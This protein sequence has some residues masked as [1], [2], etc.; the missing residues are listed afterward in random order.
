MPH[1][2]EDLLTYPEHR[3]SPSYLFSSVRVARSLVF[4]VML[5]RSVFVLLPWAILLF[6][7]RIGIFKVSFIEQQVDI[8][9]VY[10]INLITLSKPC[11]QILTRAISN[12]VKLYVGRYCPSKSL[13]IMDVEYFLVSL[14][15][16]Q[17]GIMSQL[18][19]CISK[20]LEIKICLF[21]TN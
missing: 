16:L 2:E 15:H 1:V 20:L 3:R 4:C 9:N 5:Y 21:M 19:Q 10:T 18:P 12:I 11:T 14:S 7:L 13:Q 8:F 17:N 6:V